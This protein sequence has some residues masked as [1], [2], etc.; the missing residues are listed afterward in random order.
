MGAGTSIPEVLDREAAME[1]TGKSFDALAFDSMALGK[2]Y[3]T[4]DQLIQVARQ[5]GLEAS[6][7]HNKKGHFFP[8]SDQEQDLRGSGGAEDKMA[9]EGQRGDL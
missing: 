6:L 7:R 8:D 9:D 2:G 3:I 5:R 4:R 1:L